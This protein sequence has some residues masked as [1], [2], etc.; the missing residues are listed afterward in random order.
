MNQSD[1]TANSM[2]IGIVRERDD[3]KA[4]NYEV[5]SNPE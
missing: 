4:G 1:G 3:S 5:A 2:V